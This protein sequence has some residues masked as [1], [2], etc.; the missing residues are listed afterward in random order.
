MLS[1]AK[2]LSAFRLDAA[3]ADEADFGEEVRLANAHL[4]GGG[5]QSPIGGEEIWAQR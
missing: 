1:A 4:K 5:S 3:A 2:R